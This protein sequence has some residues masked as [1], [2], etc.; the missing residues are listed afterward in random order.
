MLRGGWETAQLKSLLRNNCDGSFTDVTKEAGLAMPTST[1]AAVWLD[2]NNDGY[3]DLFVG[4]E[5]GPSQLFLNQGDGTFVDIAHAAGVDRVAFSKGAVAEDYDHDG[6]VDLYVSNYRGDN[7]LFRNNHDLTFTDVARQAGVA[8]TGHTFPVWFFDY[9][10]DGWA[11]LLVTSYNMSVAEMVRNFLALPHNAGTMK[12][13]KNLGNGAFRDVTVEM[14]LDKA[15]MP[16]GANFGDVDNDGYPDIYLG[17]GDP[18]YTSLAPHMLFHNQ[19]GKAFA[20]ITASS[21]TGELHKG[22]AVAFAD[23]DNDGDEDILTVTGGA[24][25]GDSHMFRLFENPGHGNDWISVK[26]QGV[27]AN[28]SALGARIKV[29]VRNAGRERAVYRTVSSGGSFGASPLEQHI[30]LGKSAQIVTLEIIWPGDPEHPQ[31]FT[32]LPVNQAIAIKQGAAEYRK[33]ERHPVHLG[34][35]QRTVVP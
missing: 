7:A 6:Y 13:Y 2:I 35:A 17:A 20:D 18:S 27:K 23:I 26:L 19:Q 33:I 28:R 10:N 5:N 9:D 31:K 25:R 22:H 12:L 30:G 1:Q 3:L 8:G 21:G 34:G 14:G 15:L 24:V 11:D 16:M 4:N 29:T 32:D